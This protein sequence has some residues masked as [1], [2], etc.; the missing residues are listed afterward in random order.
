MFQLKP[1]PGFYLI[2]RHFLFSNCLNRNTGFFEDFSRFWDGGDG[3]LE[4]GE[5]L[6]S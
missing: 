6:L 1:I 5:L 2:L 4:D 3:E